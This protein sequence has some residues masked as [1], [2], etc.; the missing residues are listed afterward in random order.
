MYKRRKRET[1][2]ETYDAGTCRTCGETHSHR[3]AVPGCDSPGTITD[4]INHA[5]AGTARWVCRRHYRD[6]AA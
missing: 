2:P 3:C 4:S 5:C 1:E 6:Y